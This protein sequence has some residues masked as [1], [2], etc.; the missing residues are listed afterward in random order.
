[1]NHNVQRLLEE[2]QLNLH[3]LNGSYSEF[4]RKLKKDQKK[5]EILVNNNSFQ[6]QTQNHFEIFQELKEIYE[7]IRKIRLFFKKKQEI[8]E[9]S[10]SGIWFVLREIEKVV[11][12]LDRV[13][14]RAEVLAGSFQDMMKDLERQEKS[15]KNSDFL[16]N[17]EK[18]LVFT[19]S[20]PLSERVF[21]EDECQVILEKMNSV[22]D[23]FNSDLPKFCQSSERSNFSK[24]LPK[25]LNSEKILNSLQ[26][27]NFQLKNKLRELEDNFFY[28]TIEL[29]SNFE[30]VC[31]EKSS[32]FERLKQTEQELIQKNEK[33][34][35]IF[36]NFE[37]KDL[38]RSKNFQNF[39]ILKEKLE[40][41]IEELEKR[42]KNEEEENKEKSRIVNQLISKNNQ[43]ENE[44]KIFSNNAKK[45]RSNLENL[46][47]KSKKDQEN[48]QNFKNEVSHLS[49]SLKTLEN[50]TKEMHSHSEVTA[51]ESSLFQK[52]SESLQL[53]ETL[54]KTLKDLK[55]TKQTLLFLSQDHESLKHLH[56]SESSELSKKLLNSESKNQDLLNELNSYKSKLSSLEKSLS[57]EP[58]SHIPETIDLKSLLLSKESLETENQSLIDS[59]AFMTDFIKNMKNSYTEQ[60]ALLEQKLQESQLKTQ[61]ISEALECQTYLYNKQ[62]KELT[63]Q[64]PGSSISRP[65]CRQKTSPSIDS[66]NLKS[67]ETLKKLFE[68]QDLDVS[69]V[70]MIGIELN[71]EDPSN[72]FSRILELKQERDTLYLAAQKYED[73]IQELKSELLEDDEFQLLNRVISLKKGKI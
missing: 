65:L 50:Q 61:E 73:L 35:K 60:I 67:V 29:K 36:E 10:E 18:E 7:E 56:S 51:L 49:T 39:L 5:E 24:T 15:L 27:E 2:L 54:S 71:E 4:E 32:L 58:P 41:K 22:T 38:E 8:T 53:S 30:A 48:L 26:N 25:S 33:M 16:R 44:N 13:E 72:F 62:A 52:T 59:Q 57:L 47:E 40:E 23:R 68:K 37:E 21:Y 42:L 14:K 17:S 64:S 43:L 6:L 46:S 19:Q 34:L 70:A 9:K 20:C 63:C 11:F 55:E 69:Q 1:M 31:L 28:Q 3:A 45:M 12:F 66:F